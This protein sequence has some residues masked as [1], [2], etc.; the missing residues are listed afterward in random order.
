MG[1]E[2]KAG[3]TWD[4]EDYRASSSQQKKWGRELVARLGLKGAEHVLDIGCG[5]G[6]LTAEIAA[7]VPRGRVVGIDSSPEMIDL[8]RRTFPPRS[9]PNL[10]WE[11]MDAAEIDFTEEFDIAFSNAVLHWVDDQPAVLRGVYGALKP[12]GR[13]VFQMGGRGN[14]MDVAMVLVSMLAREEWNRYF[15]DFVLPY[16]FGDPVEFEGWLREAGLQP[17]R[18]ELVDRDMVQPGREGL[19]A[20]VR[21]TWLPF[22]Q[23]IP[24]ERREEFIMELVEG[25]L[26]DFPLDAEGMAHVKAVRLEVEAVKPPCGR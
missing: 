12:G 26:A 25:Y 19:A 17:L 1:G 23:R 24:E 3:M 20:W 4:A 6:E 14:A 18:V 15:H 21:T 8:A 5:D 13:L 16:R 2:R 7:L 10:H 11:L 22:T 9:F